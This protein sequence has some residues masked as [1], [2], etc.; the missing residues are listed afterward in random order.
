MWNSLKKMASVE[1]Y[2]EYG[3]RV[4]L[5]MACIRIGAPRQP[6]SDA[7]REAARRQMASIHSRRQNPV[8]ITYSEDAT[9]PHGE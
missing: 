7:Q 8:N 3:I 6:K 4:V 9:L 5:P 1:R 2:G